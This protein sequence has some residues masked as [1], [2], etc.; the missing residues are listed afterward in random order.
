MMAL[1]SKQ[2]QKIYAVD[3]SDKER[4]HNY[5]KFQCVLSSLKE[6]MEIVLLSHIRF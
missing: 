3:F 2:L 6:L 5:I 4:H 1:D